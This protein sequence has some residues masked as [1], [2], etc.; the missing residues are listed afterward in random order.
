MMNRK[1]AKSIVALLVGAALLLAAGHAS[2]QKSKGKT[3]PAPTKYLMAGICKPHC[4]AL[5]EQLKDSGPAD[6]KAWDEAAC[7]AA[8]LSELGHLLMDDGRCPDGSWAGGAKKLQ[9]CG[10]VLLEAATVKDLAAAK[11]AF[12]ALTEGCATCHKAHKQ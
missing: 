2:A 5:A 8:C 11:T 7:H 10:A 9:D 1:C 3:R 12:K 6:G 4:S